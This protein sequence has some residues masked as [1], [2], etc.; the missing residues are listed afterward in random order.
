MDFK[1]RF[2]TPPLKTPK[3]RLVGEQVLPECLIK[4]GGYDP[5]DFPESEPP[6]EKDIQRAVLRLREL[7]KK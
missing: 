6:T 4:E 7:P 5:R 2:K 3:F 1:K